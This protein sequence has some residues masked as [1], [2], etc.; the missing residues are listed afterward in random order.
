[1]WFTLKA[2]PVQS[3]KRHFIRSPHTIGVS[4][5]HQHILYIELSYT[6]QRVQT[7]KDKYLTHFMPINWPEW[8]PLNSLQ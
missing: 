2:M 5:S 7:F 1:M 6:C 8:P 4:M 3:I